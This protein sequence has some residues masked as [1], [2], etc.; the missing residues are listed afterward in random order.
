MK[1]F[2]NSSVIIG[3]TCAVVLALLIAA[4]VLGG[5]VDKKERSATNKAQLLQSLSE[6]SAI[7]DNVIAMMTRGEMDAAKKL[8]ETT[9]AEKRAELASSI[10]EKAL[11]QMI[12]EEDHAAVLKELA[13]K[14]QEYLKK[15]AAFKAK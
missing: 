11:S 5:C 10:D 7:Q 14:E 6:L 13:N 4:V 12:L 9:V 3:K 15:L 2:Q 1:I 8:A